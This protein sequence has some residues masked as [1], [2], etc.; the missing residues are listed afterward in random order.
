[1]K[2]SPIEYLEGKD[3]SLILGGPFFQLLKRVRLSGKRLEFVK[4]RVIVISMVAWLPLLLLSMLNGQAWGDS[5]N[6][7]FIEDLD[8]HI[9]YLLAVPIM[10][11]AEL[12]V[13]E[14]ISIIVKEFKERNLLPESEIGKFHNAIGSALRLRNSMIA[15]IAMV[16][17]IYGIGYQL[18]W[19]QAAGLDISTWYSEPTSE[20]GNLSLAGIWF[21]YMSLPIFQFLFL[22]WYYRIFIWAR[23]LYQVSK[24]K[25]QLI[26]THPDDVGG[27]GFM[28]NSI[29]AFMP[30]AF[31]HGTLLS[32]LITNHIFHTGAELLDFTILIIVV[33]VIVVSLIILPLFMFSS[34]LSEAKRRGSMEYG[35][36]ASRFVKGFDE[37]WLKGKEPFDNT[38]VGNDIQS[39]ADLAQ[40]FNVVEKMQFAPITKS[41]VIML[42]AVTITPVLP[43]V[44]TMMPISELVKLLSGVLF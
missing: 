17:L 20:K 7:P 40:S 43:L 8:V 3:F 4:L 9:R 32:G 18:I 15:E 36:F 2:N 35:R 21:R 44:L 6:L 42:V 25:L 37:R 12:L 13:H 38:L 24:I 30:L 31:A 39:L 11:I 33:I 19:N 29:Y 14:R 27:L 28:A 10:I 23:F 5:L 22:R 16:A 41:N 1:M 26:P 34:Q